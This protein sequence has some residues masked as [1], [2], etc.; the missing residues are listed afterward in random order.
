MANITTIKDKLKAWTPT[1]GQPRYYVNDWKEIIGLDVDYYNTGN[2]KSVT[3]EGT[4]I[5]NN[6]YNKKLSSTKV[7]FDGEG[8]VHVD[9]CSDEYFESEIKSKVEAKYQ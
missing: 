2:V 4:D 9:Y 6:R 7:Y 1:N 5:S 3:Y 8:I